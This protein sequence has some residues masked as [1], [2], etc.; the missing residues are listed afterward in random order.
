MAWHIT[1]QVDIKSTNKQKRARELS[2]RSA[3]TQGGNDTR[4]APIFCVCQAIA[5]GIVHKCA[6]CSCP[7]TART[8]SAITGLPALAAL[9]GTMKHE[10]MI[11]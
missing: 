4:A 9:A 3:A 2:T 1:Y 6:P 11:L 5:Y 7:R 10:C 8:A